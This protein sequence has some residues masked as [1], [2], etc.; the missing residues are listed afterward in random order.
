MNPF[1][2]DTLVQQTTADYLFN[3]LG[4][5]ESVYAFDEKFG[6]NG[7]LGR[8]TEQEVVLVRYLRK[9]LEELNPNLPEEAYRDAVRKILESSSSQSILNTN[10]ARDQVLR[11]GV[12]V[13]FRNEK[14]ER[15][16][17]RLRIFDFEIPENNHFLIV[18][19]L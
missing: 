9:K 3:D 8:D 5:D 6:E 2:E 1:T 14:G 15:N 10:R 16:K 18:R 4:W 7:T 12:E 11:N 13:I 17:K 19:E